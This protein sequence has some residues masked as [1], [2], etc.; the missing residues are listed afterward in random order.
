MLRFIKY[1]NVITKFDDINFIS[2]INNEI[3]ISLNNGCKINLYYTKEGV[4]LL[5]TK[6][7][8]ELNDKNQIVIDLDKLIEFTKD[9]ECV[10]MEIITDPPIGID[11]R[12][13]F[14]QNYGGESDSGE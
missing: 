11:W 6:L 13:Q 12:D 3:I 4:D 8:E 9:T 7:T 10:K 14:L 1:Q 2:N 5:F